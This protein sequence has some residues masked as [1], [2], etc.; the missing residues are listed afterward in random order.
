MDQSRFAFTQPGYNVSIVENSVGKTYAAPTVKMGVYLSDPTLDV[1]Y[2]IVEGD[3]TRVFKPESRRVGDFNFLMLRTRSGAHTV[4]N[5]EQQDSYRLVVRANAK[6]RHGPALSARTEILV[7]VVDANDLS[8]LF[9]LQVY[10][11]DVMETT[12]LHQSIIRVTASDADV[13]INGEIYYSFAEPSETFAIHPTTGV[14]MLTSR[15]NFQQ[16]SSYQLEIFARDRGPVSERGAR[17]SRA[18]LHIKVLDVN[19]HAPQFAH[20][21]LAAIVEHG[22]VGTIYAI[23]SVHDDDPGRNGLIDRVQ[24]IDGDPDRYFTLQ[25]GYSDSEYVIQVAK[26]L[27][28]ESHPNGF[29]LTIE[30]ADRGRPARNSSFVIHVQ[31]QDTN[32]HAPQFSTKTYNVTVLECLP[33]HTPVVSVRASDTDFGKNAEISYSIVRG[34]GVGLF[35]IGPSTGILSIASPLDVEDIM[36]V[37]IVV[38]VHDHANKG[39]RKIGEALVRIE[40]GDCNDNLPIFSAVPSVIYVEENQP[41]GT[42]VFQVEAHDADQGDNGFISYSLANVD[43]VSFAIDHFTG[44]ILSKAPLDYES[45][46]RV[47]NLVVRASDWGTPFRRESEIVLKVR[48]RDVNDNRPQFEKINC[49][50]FLSREAPI[51]TEIVV[52]SAIDFDF[53]NIISYRILS[54]NDD[55]CLNLDESSGQLSTVCSLKNDRLDLRSIVITASDG[56]NNAEPMTVNISLVNNS[57]NRKLMNADANFSC[58]DTL[59]TDELNRLLRTADQNNQ[60]GDSEVVNINPNYFSKNL[61]APRFT[62]AQPKKIAVKEGLSVGTKV[63]SLSAVDDDHGFNS[64]L[65]FVISGGNDRDVFKVDTFTGDLVIMGTIDRETKDR[66]L[67][68]ITVLDMGSPQ[69]YAYTLLEVIVDDINDNA[70]EFDKT[71]YSVT[72]SEDTAINTTI[73]EVM[74][75]DRDMGANGRVSYHLVSDSDAFSMDSRSGRIK[76]NSI[77]DREQQT[78]HEFIVAA[79]DLSSE[80]PLSTTVVVIVKLDD[81]ND[82]TPKFMPELYRVQVLEDL[83]VGTV[84]ATLFARDPDFGIS[85]SVRYSFVGGGADDTFDI[86]RNTGTVRIA[87]ELNFESKQ[88]YNITAKAKDRGEP[89]LTATCT[90]IIEVVDVSKNLHAPTFR[91]FVFQGRVRENQPPRTSVMQVIATDKDANN[92]RASPQDYHVLYSI[93]DGS[94]LGRFTIDSKGESPLCIPFCIGTLSFAINVMLTNVLFF[95]M[96]ISLVADCADTV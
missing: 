38:Q 95:S 77:L 37:D 30:A 52:V 61:N 16:H 59:V 26:V 75:R 3:P 23:L 92:P 35:T 9:D 39:S 91:D 48:I 80:N 25:K 79:V 33:V 46:R 8:P 83:P 6:Y 67:L 73:L 17:V 96:V 10:K 22:A 29:N 50:G 55:D 64:K 27:D 70:P 45:M 42:A 71:S 81:V 63:L 89:V 41:F 49:T 31:L 18:S 76:V 66:Y 19:V 60:G 7:T 5:R 47:Y 58:R 2:A 84:V 20:Q 13:G 21:E 93:R 14:V 88:L 11:V 68:N 90:V 57:R 62:T 86:D 87:K 32:D 34:S 82:N 15:L 28:R 43:N 12:S 65:M 44:K 40:I 94:G 85:G 69:K 72:V 36:S 53:G 56:T 4:I 74:A 24:I 51:G 78:V 1:N 54:G